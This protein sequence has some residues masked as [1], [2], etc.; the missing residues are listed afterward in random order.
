MSAKKAE[1]A[2]P[3]EPAEKKS[4]W[5]VERGSAV[6]KIYLTPHG[7]E[8]Y[9]TLS[10]WVDGKRKRQVFPTLQQAKGVATER[11]TQMTSRNSNSPTH[12]HSVQPKTP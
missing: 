12:R 3:A 2:K 7:E 9:Y 10:Y 4:K 6:V 11:A 5:T 1:E 8:N